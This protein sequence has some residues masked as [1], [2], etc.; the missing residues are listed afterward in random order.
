MS[1]SPS[2]QLSDTYLA[3][4]HTH[5]DQGPQASLQVAHAVG[6]EAVALGLETLDLA[7][8]HEHALTQLQQL[9]SAQPCD[10]SA[11]AAGF[12]TE[13]ITPIEETHRAARKSNADLLQLQ[14]ALDERM[15]NLA[16]ANRDLQQQVAERE[17]TESALRESQRASVRLLEDSRM[18]EKELQHMARKILSATEAER[19]KMSLQLNDE[20]AQTLLGINL[21]I[22]ALKNDVAANHSDFTHEID[23]TKR[24]VED[25]AKIISRLAH[26]FTIQHER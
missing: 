5:F 6:R 17:V 20:I 14:A 10:L 7:R 26:E 24:L 4:L 21:R 3:A 18:L 23:A 1:K 12:F 9:G 25:S 22:L 8:I 13:A 16:A 2:S 15:L 19:H 11:R